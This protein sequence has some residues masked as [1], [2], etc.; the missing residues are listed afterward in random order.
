MISDP[1]SDLLIRLKN[2]NRAGK[3]EAV[4]PHSKLRLAVLELL[5]KEGYVGDINKK[6]KK[7]K[8]ILEV[9]LSYKDKR[10]AIRGAKRVSLPSRRVYYRARDVH[11]VKY[12]HGLLVLSTSGGLMTN[13]EARK[14]RVGGEALFEIW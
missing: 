10:P 4:M 9:V 14:A 6:G 12:G 5:A 11:P 8:K 7:A 13:K 2:A 1:I 3:S